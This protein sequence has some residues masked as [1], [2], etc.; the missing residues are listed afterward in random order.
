MF[1]YEIYHKK[2]MSKNKEYKSNIEFFE[3]IQSGVNNKGF[4]R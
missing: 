1:I 3:Y 2:V 4:L